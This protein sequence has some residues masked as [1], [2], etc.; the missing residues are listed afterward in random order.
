MFFGFVGQALDDRHDRIV[1]EIN[2]KNA[3]IRSGNVTVYFD[4]Y[5]GNNRCR[6][7]SEGDFR[8][9]RPS[10]CIIGENR[11]LVN[12]AQ[13]SSAFVIDERK[14]LGFIYFASSLEL[15]RSN[16]NFPE[17]SIIIQ[18]PPNDVWRFDGNGHAR[19][20]RMNITYRYG[21]QATRRRNKEEQ[22]QANN[23]QLQQVEQLEN[24]S[25]ERLLD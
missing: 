22:D 1:E 21:E 25:L 18:M 16:G 14:E 9:I 10:G 13:Q 8:P 11:V 15:L 17:K 20:F 4:N 6:L 3:P 5:S 19:K 24:I 2:F 23:A 12:C 7:A